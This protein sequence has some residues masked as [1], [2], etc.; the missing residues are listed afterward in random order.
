VLVGEQVWTAVKK[1]WEELDI[2]M[3]AR[4]FVSHS[5]I[6][7]AIHADN[8]EDSITRDKN[9]LHCGVRR[10]TMPYFADNDVTPAGVTVIQLPGAALTDE[11]QRTGLKYDPPDVTNLLQRT[12]QIKTYLLKSELDFFEK[13]SSRRSSFWQRVAVINWLKNSNE[14]ESVPVP[15]DIQPDMPSARGELQTEYDEVYDEAV[16]VQPSNLFGEFKVDS[17]ADE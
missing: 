14:L 10:S 15:V 9:G 1:A 4:A 3:L 11:L 6:V 8:G 17:D 12:K 13:F 16:Q 5:Q 2:Q 7:N